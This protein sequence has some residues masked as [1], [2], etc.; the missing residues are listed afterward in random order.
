MIE[1]MQPSGLQSSVFRFAK[2]QLFIYQVVQNPQLRFCARYLK[3]HASARWC[4]GVYMLCHLSDP[5]GTFSVLE[6]AI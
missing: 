4:V 2:E 6:K 5:L 1:F 3:A